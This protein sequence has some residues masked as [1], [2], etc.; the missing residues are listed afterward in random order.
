MTLRKEARPQ[1][2]AQGVGIILA[3][4]LTMAFADAVVKLVSANLTLWQVFATRSLVALP[5]LTLLL[6]ATGVGLR[7]RAPMWA[8]VR[9]GLLVLA[10]LAYYA[11]LPVLSL[12]V[13]AVAVYTGPI[14]IALMSAALIGE[15]VTGRQWGG[16]LLGFLG[17]IAILKP[18][19]EAFSWFTFLPLLGAAFY[20]LAMVL[21]RSKCQDEAPLS[22]ALALQGSFLV[23][24][25]IATGVL[26]LIGLGADTKAAY[27]FLL[28]DWAPM[29]L[30]AW[31]L[32]ALLGVLS[33]AYFAGVAR[34]YQI[35]P[36]SIIAT[37][38]Y[39][40]LVSA[41]L[42]GFVLFSE[43][44]DLL[45]LGGMILITVAGLLVAAPNS[46]RTRVEETAA[47]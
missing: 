36:P 9:S 17:V 5:I 27:P 28:G 42:W 3:S 24:G 15:A 11:S 12:S 4:V 14:M 19:T 6:L 34:A 31:G 10:W 21:T 16:V 44:P 43:T 25:L 13:A 1:R 35:A 23:A 39:A 7:P 32:M 20:A 26:A 22:L 33:A 40:Y 18:G 38:D 46:R 45:T 29:D 37:F 41:A 47:P 30:R 8:F 2:T